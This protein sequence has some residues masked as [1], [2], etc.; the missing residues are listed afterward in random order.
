MYRDLKR[1]EECIVFPGTEVSGAH[2]L[3][4]VGA[5]N[6][7]WGLRKG[8]KHPELFLQPQTTVV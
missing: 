5:G 1:L 2:E 7:L 6:K 3:P 8:S 4:S